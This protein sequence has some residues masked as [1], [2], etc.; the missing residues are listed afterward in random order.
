MVDVIIIG[1]GAAGLAAARIISKSGK[2]VTV[3]EARNRVGGRIYT[4][5]KGDFSFPVEAGAEFVHGN[6][7]HTTALLKEAEVSFYETSGNTWNVHNGEVS[8]G[9]LFPDE[10]GELLQK[11]NAL[12]HDM[13]I[14]QFLD[15]YFHD[16]K[17][18]ALRESIVR[19]VQGYDAAD[20]TKASA[21]ALRDEWS[22]EDSLTGYRPHGGYSLLIDFL[23]NECLQQ[24]SVFHFNS[25]V[26]EI[27]HNKDHVEVKTEGGERYIAKKLL[28]TIPP[29]VIKTGSVVF[30][31]ALG[32]HM[33]AIQK[34]ETGSVIKFLVE[35]KSAFWEKNKNAAP[36]RSMPGLQFVFSDASIPTWWTQQP[37]PDPLL[38]G[39][40]AG[41]AASDN[42]KDENALLHEAVKALAY[43][44]GCTIQAIEEQI[45]AMTVINWGADHF[46]RG[47]YA[48][49]TVDTNS[50]LAILSEPVSNTIYF[51]GEAFYNGPEMGT[52]EAALASG[53]TTAQ[54]MLA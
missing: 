33:N 37:V 52:V 12:E 29:A 42:T 48:Y 49:K 10:W 35:F 1:A 32:D 31:P 13:S 25:V 7:P 43:I 41:P 39:W 2:S 53:T 17:Y 38:T 9:D 28:V 45:K 21:F 22:G 26:Q 18:T 14:A 54:K 36:Y 16:E 24:G 3:L 5:Q 8:E 4:L 6:L 44:F 47:A 15:R 20:T 51:A 30:T 50:A 23:V 19:F 27:Y 40:L 46:S 34:I 11:L